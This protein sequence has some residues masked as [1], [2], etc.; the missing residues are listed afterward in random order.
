MI[1]KTLC[2]NNSLGLHARAAGR[3]VEI[4]NQF[5]SDIYLS[6]D[7]M[8][9]DAKSIMGI[10]AMSA[11]KDDRVDVTIDGIDEEE[12]MNSIEKLIDS[13]LDEIR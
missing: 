10:I 3:F 2:I 6:K 13:G 7:N 4:T 9:V 5:N 11:H 12:A 1:K 8:V